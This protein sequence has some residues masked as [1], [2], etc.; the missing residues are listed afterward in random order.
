MSAREGE[1]CSGNCESE[2]SGRIQTDAFIEAA[3]PITLKIDGDVSVADGPYLLDDA[4]TNVGIE[5][6]REFFAGDF[7][8]RQRSCRPALIRGRELVMTHPAYS[9]AQ[10][11]KDLLSPFDCAQ[12][13]AGDFGMVGN[14][15]RQACRRGLVPRAQAGAARQLTNFRLGQAGFVEGTPHAKLARR[16][17]ARP[18]VATVVGI[19]AVGHHRK[20]AI[21]CNTG[22]R[23][24]ELVLAV[25][26]AIGGVRLVLRAIELGRVNDLVAQTGLA[27][28]G[29]GKLAMA[30]GVTRAIGGNTEDRLSQ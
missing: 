12:L 23:C 8:S 11:S 20:R 4:G 24:V 14:A 28:N 29:Y 16:L 9:K 18:I 15:R 17:S 1:G 27:G 10:R 7:E 26:T 25:V 21:G 2:K 22:Q 30:I 19:A 13:L 5:R 6:A 3:H